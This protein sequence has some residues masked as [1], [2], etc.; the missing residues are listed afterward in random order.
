MIQTHYIKLRVELCGAVLCGD[1]CF[2]VRKN[3]RGYQKGDRIVFQAVNSA[4][5]T[6]PHAVNREAYE[7]TYVL[8]GWGL[9]EEFCVFGI[10]PWK[11]E[12]DGEEEDDHYKEET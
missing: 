1:K 12:K 4:G 8:H 2:E 9:Q 7:I 10:K 3:D 11:D 6:V 5:L